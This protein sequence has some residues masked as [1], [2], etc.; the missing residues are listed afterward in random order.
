METEYLKFVRSEMDPFFDAIDDPSERQ[1]IEA[2][3]MTR[4]LNCDSL[5]NLCKTFHINKD[6]MYK[7]LDAITPPRWL[8]RLIKRGRQKLAV[9]LRKWHNGDPSFQSRH[10]I[11]F[12][13]DDF[14][15][16]ARGSRGGVAG[17]FYSGAE[18]CVVN[19]INVEILCAVIG[20]GDEFIILD[21]RIV[22]PKPERGADPLNQNEWLRRSL[23]NLSSFLGT[24][25]TNLRKCP[26]SVDAA[27]V[28]PENVALVKNLGMC[29][30]SKLAA[31][32][33]V[34]GYVDGPITEKVNFFA[35]YAVFDNHRTFHLLRGESEVEYQRNIVTVPSLDTE[36]LMVTFILGRD[37]LVYFST[38]TAMK[39]IT[40]RNILR[41][42]W[43]LERFFWILKQDIGIG[44]IHHQI[45]ERV[46]V[47]IYLH[48]ILAQAV[49]G[50]SRVFNCSPKDIIRTIRGFPNR[51]LLDLGFPS[52]FAGRV[53]LESVPQVPLAA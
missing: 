40:L 9:H 27:Y 5:L 24:Q 11:T 46:E 17:L 23:R 47:R 35:P 43:Q 36:A 33:I 31:N 32:R 52:A 51:V 14:T 6:S 3:T 26:L 20:D 29:M 10:S 1:L 13:A 30:V 34:T 12:C 15:C 49:R 18:K 21:I 37:L 44:D 41:Y 45:K 38:N 4:L 50:A 22:P 8:R 25:G 2:A 28:S 53:P 16:A 42:R 19:G 39:A 7:S 48:V